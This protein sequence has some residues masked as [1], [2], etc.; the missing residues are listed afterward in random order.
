MVSPPSILVKI[1][2]EGCVFT[3]YDYIILLSK[4]S[5]NAASL[6]SSLVQ[7]QDHP[8]YSQELLRNIFCISVPGVTPLREGFTLQVNRN[9]EDV[10]RA[11][12]GKQVICSLS[13]F[14]PFL[15]PTSPPVPSSIFSTV[16]LLCSRSPPPLPTQLLQCTLLWIQTQTPFNLQQ[17]NFLLRSTT[18]PPWPPHH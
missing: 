2:G 17:Q 10:S 4:Q 8:D 16:G 11:L 5:S 18:P 14:L 15:R 6:M 12:F 3:L 1:Y 9:Q 7:T 13:Q